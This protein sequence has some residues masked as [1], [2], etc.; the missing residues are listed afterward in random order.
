MAVVT[1]RLPNDNCVPSMKTSNGSMDL[2]KLVGDGSGG[3]SAL[4]YTSQKFC[5]ARAGVLNSTAVAA[6]TVDETAK[7]VTVT[8]GAS[9]TV[10]V[11]ILSA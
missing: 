7:T 6:W 5:G 10:Y 8:V 11:E 4:P 1:T 9:A 2:F 3:T